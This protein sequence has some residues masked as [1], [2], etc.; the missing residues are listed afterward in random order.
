MLLGRVC[1]VTAIKKIQNYTATDEVSSWHNLYISLKVV[2]HMLNYSASLSILS[3]EAILYYI[4]YIR[5]QKMPAAFSVTR[6]QLITY[7][8]TTKIC[9]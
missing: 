8:Q 4:I 7:Y 5:D 9:I 2:E 3:V 6:Y 1:Y